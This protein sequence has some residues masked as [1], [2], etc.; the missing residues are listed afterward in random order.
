MEHNK[1][2]AYI[3]D[4]E[5]TTLYEG[6]VVHIEPNGVEWKLEWGYF[7]DPHKLYVGNGINSGREVICDIDE[8]YEIINDE[9]KPIPHFIKINEKIRIIKI[10]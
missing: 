10:K 3:E 2:L 8:W 7:G 4:E 6:D 1:R 5:G 9:Y